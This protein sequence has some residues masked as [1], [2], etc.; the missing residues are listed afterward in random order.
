[1]V[2]A[3]TSAV[4]SI[5]S[6]KQDEDKIVPIDD[7]KVFCISGEAGDRV[8]FTEYIIGNVKLYAL[9]NSTEL[10]TKS[11]AHYTRG[12]L[13]TAL[14][15]VSSCDLTWYPVSVKAT[16]KAISKSPCELGAVLLRI[17]PAFH[18][19]M[20][21]QVCA[22]PCHA[23]QQDAWRTWCS[24]VT[25]ALCAGHMINVQLAQRGLLTTTCCPVLPAV[26]VPLQPAAG[27]L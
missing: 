26:A 19:I 20:P 16:T 12:E 5:I 11:V 1:M 24:A 7:H 25:A 13:A 14:R 4:H 15:K 17:S 9:R 3:D 23:A 2:C 10:S 21:Q 6:I 22:M 18:R 27:W 8:N